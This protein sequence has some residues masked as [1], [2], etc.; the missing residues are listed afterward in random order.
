[1]LLYDPGKFCIP[2][3]TFSC[4]GF[5]L[6]KAAEVKELMSDFGMYILH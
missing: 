3:V 6:K 2:A 4:T 1:M 5:L